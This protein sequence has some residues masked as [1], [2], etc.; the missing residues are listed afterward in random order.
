MGPYTEP[1]RHLCSGNQR[2]IKGDLT[3]REDVSG[4]RNSLS[5]LTKTAQPITPVANTA[6]IVFD[7]FFMVLFELIIVESV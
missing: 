3:A 6:S 4:Y 5:L 1:V 7:E 2:A